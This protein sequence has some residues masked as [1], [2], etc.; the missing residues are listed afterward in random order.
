MS[1]RGVTPNFSLPGLVLCQNI[2]IP[3]Q[4][5]QI[6][7]HS[8]ENAIIILAGSC[9]REKSQHFSSPRCPG[10]KNSDFLT[11]GILVTHRY[12]PT[13]PAKW[14]LGKK[15]PRLGASKVNIKGPFCRWTQVHR[16][17]CGRKTQNEILPK[18]FPGSADCT[19]NVRFASFCV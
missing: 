19:Q 2:Q 6:P 3:H 14:C 5:V 4:N 8:K 11:L 18:I 7:C 16:R 13:Y 10:K 12:D 17:N 15:M 9:C 1:W